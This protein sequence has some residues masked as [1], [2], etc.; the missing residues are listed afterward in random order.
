MNLT[1]L[2]VV[3]E[4]PNQNGQHRHLLSMT[5]TCFNPSGSLP[6]ILCHIFTNYCSVCI[7]LYWWVLVMSCFLWFCVLLL[8]PLSHIVKC[9]LPVLLLYPWCLL[10]VSSLHFVPQLPLEANFEFAE[11]TMALKILVPHCFSP[12]IR[13]ALNNFAN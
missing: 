6:F 11:I 13:L 10:L 8:S 3:N 1:G 5:F 12:N 4:W 9:I 7:G 2:V